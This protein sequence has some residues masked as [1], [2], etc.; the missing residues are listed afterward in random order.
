M[1]SALGV[2]A[3]LLLWTPAAHGAPEDTSAPV[4]KHEPVQ[5]S[6][7]A[8]AVTIAATISDPSGVAFPLLYFRVVGTTSWSRATM[9]AEGE[10]FRAV[11][12]AFSATKNGVEYYIEA[13]DKKGN[14][15]TYHGTRMRPHR[16]AI[17]KGKAPVATSTPWYKRWW[18]WAIG[19][20][21]VAGSVTAIAIAA[22]SGDSGNNPPSGATLVISAPPPAPT[23]PGL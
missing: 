10:T 22:S 1:R 11:I 17:K 3:L 7:P 6:A 20:A 14:G 18:I 5:S 13:F 4:I 2:L 21:V 15:P 16:I 23:L 19:G 8:R 12:P 9:V